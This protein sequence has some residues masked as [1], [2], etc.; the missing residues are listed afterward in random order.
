LTTDMEPDTLRHKSIGLRRNNDEE[1]T[2]FG[3]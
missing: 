1:N 3:M 2:L